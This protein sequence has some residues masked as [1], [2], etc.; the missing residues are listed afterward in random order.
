MKVTL[1]A[2]LVM[3]LAAFIAFGDQIQPL[4]PQMK[5]TS[6]DTRTALVKFGNGLVPGWAKKDQNKR[7]QEA[8]DKEQKGVPASQ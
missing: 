6:L 3:L 4:P 7:T 2:G 1:V 8:I 5:K